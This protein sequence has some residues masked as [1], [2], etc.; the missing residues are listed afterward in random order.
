MNDECVVAVADQCD[1]DWD[2][3]A[4]WLVVCHQRLTGG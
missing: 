3:I 4:D 1:G 2:W